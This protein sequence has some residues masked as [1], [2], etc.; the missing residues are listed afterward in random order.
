MCAIQAP[1]DE[2]KEARLALFSQWIRKKNSD[3]TLCTYGVLYKCLR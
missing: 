3:D 1:W 2:K